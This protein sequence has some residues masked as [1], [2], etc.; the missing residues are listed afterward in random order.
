LRSRSASG[1]VSLVAI[2]DGIPS[3]SGG[4]AST[5]FRHHHTDAWWAVSQRH[6]QT[7][8]GSNNGKNKGVSAAL[9]TTT[10]GSKGSG[11]GMLRAAT[12]AAGAGDAAAGMNNVCSRVVTADDL[13]ARAETV[14][15]DGWLVP[16][17]ALR[18][19]FKACVK[20]AQASKNASN[21]KALKG[22][23]LDLPSTLLSTS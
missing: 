2:E 8:T 15:R 18:H 1:S 7:L 10:R 14:I 22:K 3:S 13:T 23:S 16:T 6:H 20:A 19:E 11:A 4:S 21:R 12:G 17:A 5:I 9:L